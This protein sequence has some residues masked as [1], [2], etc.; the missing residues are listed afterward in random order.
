MDRGHMYGSVNLPK[1][2]SDYFLSK[3]SGY[4]AMCWDSESEVLTLQPV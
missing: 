1:E 3:G 4:V 2:L